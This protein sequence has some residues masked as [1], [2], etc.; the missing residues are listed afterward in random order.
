MNEQEF[1]AAEYSLSVFLL[2]YDRKGK[3]VMEIFDDWIATTKF[4]FTD[5]ETM[6]SVLSVLVT[7]K[8]C[9]L[10]DLI[11]PSEKDLIPDY[12]D[13]LKYDNPEIF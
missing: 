12:N 7:T 3:D 2:T 13:Y 4:I 5:K 11:V 9:S 8:E 10:D 6:K 1:I